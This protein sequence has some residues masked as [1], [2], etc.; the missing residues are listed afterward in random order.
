MELNLFTHISSLFD[1]LSE[2]I[3]SLVKDKK[4]RARAFMTDRLDQL[5]IALCKAQGEMPIAEL[6]KNN[7][8]FKSSYADFT[9]IVATSR[10]ALTK[11]GLSVSQVLLDEDS[12]AWIITTLLHG[13][14]NQFICSRKRITPAK[15]DI[16]T[17][18]SYT[19]YLKRMCYAALIGV[20]AGDEDDD[21]ERAVATSRDTFAKGVAIGT[22]YDPSESSAQVV[23]K[24][25][26]DELEYELQGFSDIAQM[27]L[28]GLKI[29][30]LAD[31]PKSKYMIAVTRI[32]EI[33][34]L[35]NKGPRK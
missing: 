2:K 32:R 16:Q 29:S 34:A 13:E 27:V 21:G 6:N 17:I 23:S 35:R 22:K 8:Y 33:K 25:Q 28:E 9:S 20:V 19:T 14:S 12:G 18:S 24:D 26:L 15:N 10:P 5:G 3:D 31:V 1:K 7:P 4:P 30:N 11:Y